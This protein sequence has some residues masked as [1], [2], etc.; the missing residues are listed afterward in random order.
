MKALSFHNSRAHISEFE[1]DMRALDA[2]V[3][4][5]NP[6][7]SVIVLESA[8]EYLMTLIAELFE[9]V[10]CLFFSSFEKSVLMY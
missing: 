1:G 10:V 7:S 9:P 6:Y 8:V 2:G 4:D 5:S 3:Y